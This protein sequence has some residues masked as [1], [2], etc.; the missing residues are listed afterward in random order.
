MDDDNCVWCGSS[1]G[2]QLFMCDSCPC[3]YCVKCCERNFGEA[4]TEA[5]RLAMPWSCFR[6]TLPGFFTSRQLPLDTVLLNLETSFARVKPPPSEQNGDL[7]RSELGPS[8]LQLL[9]IFTDIA[10]NSS[11]S[12]MK[13][14]LYLS[15]FDFPVLYL[16]NHAIRH[17]LLSYDRLPIPALFCTPFG[18]E[19]SCRLFEHQLNSLVMM[20]RLENEQP[21]YGAL[22]G[23][24]L[25]DEPG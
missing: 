19:N 16:L 18:E 22:R 17:F 4:I 7:L 21:T 24:I 9:S 14:H 2:A 8:E 10:T 15:A 1:D 5:I 25:A 13:I 23:G 12:Q 20:R 11:H 3:I 6:C